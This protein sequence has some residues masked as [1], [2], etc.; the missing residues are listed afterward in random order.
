MSRNSLRALAALPWLLLPCAPSACG[1]SSNAT[2]PDAAADAPTASPD[3]STTP[4]SDAS[5]PGDGASAGDAAAD[6][7][8]GGGPV[9]TTVSSWV[10]TNVNADLPFADITYLMAGFNTPAAQLDANG[11]PVAGASGT[12]STE[13]CCTC[14]DILSSLIPVNR[15]HD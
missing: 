6:S 8:T 7:D 10:G 4:P 5:R 12:S 13:P 3:G 9:T 11:Y 1:S 15:I 2:A 14:Q